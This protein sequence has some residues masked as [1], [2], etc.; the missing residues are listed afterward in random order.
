MLSR[1]KK[2]LRK[3]IEQGLRIAHEKMLR[4]KMLHKDSVIYANSLGEPIYVNPEKALADML[5][6]HP[7]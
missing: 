2:S 7:D 5:A 3:K 4:E 1:D 6:A